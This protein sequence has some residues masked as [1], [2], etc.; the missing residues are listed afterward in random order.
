MA[1]D[2]LL[3]NA[4]VIPVGADQKQHVEIARDIASSFNSRYGVDVLKA[5]TP[6]IEGERSAIPGTDGRKMSKSYGNTIPIFGTTKQLHKAVMS[7]KTDTRP[8]EEPKAPEEIIVYQIYKAFATPEQLAQMHEGF[9]KGGLGYGTAKKMLFET[10]EEYIAPAREQ[11]NELMQGNSL[12]RAL[13]SGAEKAAVEAQ[14][15]LASVK[16]I[17]LGSSLS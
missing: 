10:L 12:E 6:I 5:P 9:E 7:I 14:K 1:A 16:S 13:K 4:D 11:Y 2:I 8:P 17:M 15:Q 3:Y